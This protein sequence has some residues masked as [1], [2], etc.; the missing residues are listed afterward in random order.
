MQGQRQGETRLTTRNEGISIFAF[1]NIRRAE[2]ADGRLRAGRA[3]CVEIVRFSC[4]SHWI[5]MSRSEKLAELFRVL[6]APVRVEILF[7]LRK[8]PK[9]VGALHTRLGVTQGAVS[10]HLRVLRDA[11]LVRAEKRGAF[12]HYRLDE[13]AFRKCREAVDGLFALESSPRCSCVSSTCSKK[14]KGS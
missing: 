6:S 12:V 10:Q 11:G 14:E 2:E 8:G 9:C 13:R 4:C 1:A 3:F 7:I 5:V